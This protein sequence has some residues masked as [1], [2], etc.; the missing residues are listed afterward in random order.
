MKNKLKRFIQ[1]QAGYEEVLRETAR[2][3]GVSEGAIRRDCFLSRVLYGFEPD[4]YVAFELYRRSGREKKQF[5]SARRSQ[6]IQ[7]ALNRAP[8]EELR[9][10]NEK[11]L[12]NRAYGAFIRRG[13]VYVPESGPEEL[14]ALL[15]GEEAVIVKPTAQR[16]GEGVRRV[17]SSGA[18]AD[19]DSFYRETLADRSLVEA[20]VRQ[21]PDLAAVN[22]TSV[23]T[24]R[25]CTVRSPA[26][27]VCLF[28]ASLRGGGAGSVID[29]LHA[30]GVQYPID[31][32]TGLITRGGV[33]FDGERNILFHPSTG[34]QMIG[35]RIPH[36][37]EV[38]RTVTEAAR[39]PEHIRY[40]GWDVAVTE[41]GCELI[42]ANLSQ[43]RNGMQADGVGKY[44]IVKQYL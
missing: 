10:I 24:I 9:L 30:G 19:Y 7:K 32:K 1:G 18:L 11:H 2:R 21:H 33:K 25:A 14:R 15:E 42:E 3:C 39:I 22:P 26:G 43:G 44:A 34:K 41:E 17:E 31:V 13:W 35:F 23:N 8:E 20:F 37:E 40:V 29:N 38:R 36:W 6:E 16:R 12:F 5:L 28:A 27:E 4:E